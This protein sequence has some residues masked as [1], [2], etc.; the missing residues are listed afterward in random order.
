L[1]KRINPTHSE[2]IDGDIWERLFADIRGHIRSYGGTFKQLADAA[3]LSEA[4]VSK[5]AY[6][7]TS[8][9]HMRTIIRIM[10]ALGK[11]DPVLKAFR[12]EKPVSITQAYCWKLARGKRKQ[13]LVAKIKPHLAKKTV[14]ASVRRAGQIVH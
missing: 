3:N 13:K 4:T 9:P 5:L 12:S 8:S 10:D 2:G 1:N 7:E 6:G 11:S 14:R